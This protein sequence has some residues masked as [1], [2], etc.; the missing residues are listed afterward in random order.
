MLRFAMLR[1]GVGW[2]RITRPLRLAAQEQVKN[3][4]DSD[5]EEEFGHANLAAR[6]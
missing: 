5:D 6:I 4:E 3:D 2:R 1:C